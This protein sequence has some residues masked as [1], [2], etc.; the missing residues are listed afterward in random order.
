MN[1]AEVIATETCA[2]ALL[3]GG[4]GLAVARQ[5]LRDGW[6]KAS[7]SLGTVAPSVRLFPKARERKPT[8]SAAVADDRAPAAA[9][10]Q[11]RPHRIVGPAA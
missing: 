1:T 6:V 8:D 2:T 9:A 4:A 7:V 11:D 10:A 5:A 3:L